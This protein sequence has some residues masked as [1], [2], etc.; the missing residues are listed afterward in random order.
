ML[1]GA[2][3]AA[4]DATAQASY[5]TA[6]RDYMANQAVEAQKTQDE[7]QARFNDINAKHARLEK[8]YL[9]SKVD[10]SQVTSGVPGFIAVL[11]AAMGTFGAS[12]SG[13]ENFAG[14]ILQSRIADNIA[15]QEKAIAI[16]RDGA[17]NALKRLTEET[18][19]LDLAKASL[20]S[21]QLGRLKAQL[22]VDMKDGRDTQRQANAVKM[23]TIVS[24][25]YADAEEERRI[26][27]Q[28]V[29]TKQLQNAP[30]TAGSRGGWA[31][32]RDQLGTA[33]ALQGVR[34]GE[35]ALAGAAAGP[36]AAKLPT[37]TAE[38]VAGLDAG[39]QALDRLDLAHAQMDRGGVMQ[40]RF[41]D[42]AKFAADVD[43]LVPVVDAAKQGGAPNES[44]MEALRSALKSGNGAKIKA[45]ITAERQILEDRKAALVRGASGTSQAPS[46]TEPQ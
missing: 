13:G 17:D 19:N 44:T 9:G 42:S 26:R 15:A 31:P 7:A 2:E 12:L 3:A 38:K 18:G 27:A 39:M 35:M 45:A 1:L 25:Q 43:A 36:G 37:S 23:H 29:V 34:K 46:S 8:D 40:E 6:M 14:K 28:G 33:S 32:V 10:P 21:I 4:Q 24:K 41:G 5:D 20:K 16:K 11:G 30:A 22:E